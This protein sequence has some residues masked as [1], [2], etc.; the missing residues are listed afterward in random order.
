[1]KPKYELTILMP[2]LDEAETLQLCID[3]ANAWIQ[4]SGVNAEVV[5]AD[6]GSTDGSQDIALGLGARVVDVPT[7]GYGAALFAGSQAA[8]SQ[9]II[10]GDSDDSYDF[11]K[12]DE[13]LAGLRAGNDLVMGNR[14]AGGIAPGAMPWK[15]KHIGN[16]AL[17]MVGRVLFKIPVRDFHCGIRGYSKAAFENMDLRTSGMEFASEMVIKARLLGMKIIEVPTTL[18]KDGR[19]RPPHLKP[20][21]DGWRHLRFMLSLSPRYLFVFPGTM[22]LALGLAAYIPLLFGPIY[23]GEVELS[24][25]SLFFAQALVILGYVSLILGAAIR[26]FGSREGL[27][28]RNTFVNRTGRLPIFEFGTLGG[29]ALVAVSAI[30]GFDALS[31]WASNGFGQLPA[32]TLIRQVSAA[33]TLFIL[34]GISTSASLLFG[35]LSLPLR[36]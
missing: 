31:H 15:N 7:R 29:L 28:P 23:L 30:F 9:Y 36:K 21:R 6:N 14:F 19:S 20:W 3:K 8:D 12:L 17:S 25:N 32:D 2:C 24:V 4:K 33:S 1:M 10:M 16:P 18:S 13:F 27:L 35:F 22:L 5:I 26:V 11:S 34:G